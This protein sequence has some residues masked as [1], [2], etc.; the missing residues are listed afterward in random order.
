M[1][2]RESAGRPL[3][4][5]CKRGRDPGPKRHVNCSRPRWAGAVCSDGEGKGPGREEIEMT[6]KQGRT[7]AGKEAVSKAKGQLFTR[8]EWGTAGQIL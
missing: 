6:E 2:L 3:C 5:C 7:R 4:F 8:H 1:R